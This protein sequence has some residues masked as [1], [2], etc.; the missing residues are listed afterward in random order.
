MPNNNLYKTCLKVITDLF[1]KILQGFGL[2]S[3]FMTQWEQTL[4]TNIFHQSDPTH[5]IF[6][7]IAFDELNLVLCLRFYFLFFIKI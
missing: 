1:I 2:N 5:L 4:C 7:L 6:D 3:K